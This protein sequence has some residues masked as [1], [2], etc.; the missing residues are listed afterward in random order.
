MTRRDEEEWEFDMT[1]DI[2]RDLVKKHKKDA[3]EV[4]EDRVIAN[5]ILR[6]VVLVTFI[7]V[8]ACVFGTLFAAWA[9]GA[10]KW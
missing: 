1:E 2:T 9:V 3:A 8:S 10:L 4:F 6:R 7:M 5:Y